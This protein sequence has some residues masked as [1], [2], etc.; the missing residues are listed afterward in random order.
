M[1]TVIVF[2]T[3]IHVITVGLTLLGVHT[4]CTITYNMC[5]YIH[6]VLLHTP[7]TI[8]YGLATISRLLKIIGFFGRI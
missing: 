1:H 4:P 3:C 2:T 5:Y 6:H 7:C 8:T